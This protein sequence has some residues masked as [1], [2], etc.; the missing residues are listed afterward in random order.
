MI[1][2][3][4]F[5]GRCGRCAA[6]LALGDALTRAGVEIASAAPA[7]SAPG[8]GVER[9]TRT[10]CDLCGLGEP[11]F[12]GTRDGKPVAVKG[13]PLSRVG[14]G[15]LCPRASAL[16]SATVSE[17][18]AVAPLLR[19]DPST[20]GTLEGLAVATWDEAL[21]AAVQ[22]L[23]GVREK[24]GPLGL[25]I[26]ASDGETCETYGLLGRLARAGLGTDHLDTPARLDALHAYDACR[27]VFG[28][29]ANPG[30]VEDVDAAQLVLLIGGE[31]ADS[32]PAL[33]H[34][35]LDAR[36]GGRAR[37]ALVDWRKTEAAAV[38]DLHL[39]AR[40]GSEWAL[41]RDLARTL[42]GGA[43]SAPPR[44]GYETAALRSLSSLWRE[45]RG[46]VTLV[47]PV[48]LSSPSG[49]A[50]AHEIARLHRD[51]GQWGEPGRG[52]LFLPR[53]ANATGVCALGVAPGRLPAGRRLGEARDRARTAAAWGVDADRLPA[54]R[55]LPAL[56][57][58]AA[59]EAGRIGAIVIQRANLAAEMPDALAWRRALAKTFVVATTTHAPSETTAFADV[60]LPLA[61]VSGESAGTIMTLD[62]RC[63]FIEQACEPPGEARAAE[64]ILRDLGRA[65]IDRETFERLGL[66]EGW[67]TF[68]EWDRWRALAAETGFEAGG[69]TVVR[70]G[71]ELDVQWPC[72]A[73]SVAGTA[74][75]RPAGGARNADAPQPPPVAARTPAAASSAP[76]P[77]APRAIRTD[78]GRPLLLVTGPIREHFASRVRTGRTPELHYEAPAAQ[79]EMHPE[80]GR[81]LGLADGEWVTVESAAGSATMRLW[82]TDR[83]S[84]GV[85]FLAEH[86]GFRSDLQG[87][88][89]T[90]KEPEGLAHRLTTCEM[91]PGSESPAELQVAVSVRKALR[92]DMRQRGAGS[93]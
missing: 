73:D 44:A 77:P 64:R 53:G 81:A 38:A 5:L 83:A 69:L 6:G 89:V 55:G 93:P 85:L 14:F 23:R 33:F 79:L 67:S 3:R 68:A 63:Q 31:V 2:R 52:V 80:D 28:T 46:V 35:V 51:A 58:P 65:L 88:S 90:Q 91:A 43:A 13:I 9:W 87:G 25:A 47:G 12:L 70:L 42:R 29:E 15:R 7:R 10:A 11:V 75:L 66:G 82:L 92:R 50:L 86:Y 62:R 76:A 24:M 72:G 71:R 78:P 74:R 49:A 27:A 18:R 1:T 20:K 57:W 56:A 19:R 84:P 22:G 8:D 30:S 26:F 36:R 40:P 41:V 34:R 54:A 32:H 37:V 16:V 4:G 61:M 39:R 21:A 17:D 59:I 45:A 48:A 60:V